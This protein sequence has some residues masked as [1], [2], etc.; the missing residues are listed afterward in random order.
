MTRHFLPCNSTFCVPVAVMLCAFL[1]R[2]EAEDLLFDDPE[3][4]ES[5]VNTGSNEYGGSMSSDGRTLYFWSD[6]LGSVGEGFFGSDIWVATREDPEDL[7]EDVERLGEPINSPFD[8][9]TPVISADGNDGSP[10]CQ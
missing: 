9:I 10:N 4:L 1:C 6:R 8:D 5:P 7:F 2:A 3:S